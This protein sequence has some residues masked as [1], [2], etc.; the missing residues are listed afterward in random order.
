MGLRGGGLECPGGGL[1]GPAAGGVFEPGWENCWVTGVHP[2]GGTITNKGGKAQ[3]RQTGGQRRDG[4]AE[5]RVSGRVQVEE[6][7]GWKQTRAMRT[8]QGQ[9]GF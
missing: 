5:T 3:G 8:V 7:T 4:E 1:R 2:G 9:F 6:R